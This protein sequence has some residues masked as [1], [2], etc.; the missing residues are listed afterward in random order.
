LVTCAV[1]DGRLEIAGTNSGPSPA[2]TADKDILI[3]RGWSFSINGE[4]TLPTQASSPSPADDAIDVATTIDLSWTKDLGDTVDVYFD[5]KNEHNPPITKVVDDMDV[6]TYDP[7]GSLD[8]ETTYVWK[9]VTR[10]VVGTTDGDVWEFTTI[11]QTV[12][13]LSYTRG[14]R[15]VNLG[16]NR[17]VI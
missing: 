1:E 3:G 14:T 11:K 4:V 13:E 16:L 5:K 17:G 6:S 8:V 15:G 9:V 10:N 12:S 7:P 2:G